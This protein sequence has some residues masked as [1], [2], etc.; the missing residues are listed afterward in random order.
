MQTHELQICVATAV[1][2]YN[3][4]F[5]QDFWLGLM[6]KALVECVSLFTHAIMCVPPRGGGR[7]RGFLDLRLL[8]TQSG[9]KF[10]LDR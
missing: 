8:L 6:V 3:Q 1:S 7:G 9:T 5:I 4:D 10:H 2:I